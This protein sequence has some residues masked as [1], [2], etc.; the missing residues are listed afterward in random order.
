MGREAMWDFTASLI[1]SV[2][3]I[4]GGLL[5]S[6][7]FCG[8]SCIRPVANRVRYSFFSDTQG[9]QK[10]CLANFN[11]LVQNSE[12]VMEGHIAPTSWCFTAIGFYNYVICYI[13]PLPL[14]V[15]HFPVI[16]ANFVPIIS[17]EYVI[18]FVQA[19]TTAV[20]YCIPRLN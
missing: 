18:A 13:I 15:S 17:R 12:K 8:L 11:P 19:S 7:I 16:L 9:L 6:P 14:H 4:P 3:L 2:F 1:T 5:P 20:I 10:D